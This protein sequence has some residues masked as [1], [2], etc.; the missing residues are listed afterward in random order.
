MVF[1]FHNYNYKVT[2]YPMFISKYCQIVIIFNLFIWLYTKTKITSNGGER[3]LYNLGR[4]LKGLSGEYQ[5]SC[6]PLLISDRYPPN[7]TSSLFTTFVDGSKGDNWWT[8]AFQVS[9]SK[10]RSVLGILSSYPTSIP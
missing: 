3:K 1:I 9:A 7:L 2:K 6:R 8:N 5:K 10:Y 4:N